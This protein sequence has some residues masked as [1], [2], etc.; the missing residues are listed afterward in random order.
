MNARKLVLGILLIAFALPMPSAAI[1]GQS[2]WKPQTSEKSMGLEISKPFLDG[3]HLSVLSTTSFLWVQWPIHEKIQFVG[4]LPLAYGSYDD[5]FG[6]ESDFVL[7]N[8]YLGLRFGEDGSKLSGQF[9]VRLPVT[10][11]HSNPALGVGLF[12]DFISRPGAFWPDNVPVTG[13][14]AYQVRNEQGLVLQVTGGADAWIATESGYGDR[15]EAWGL[16][17]ARAGYDNQVWAFSGGLAGRAILTES[18][19]SFA[20]RTVHELGLDIGY[21][22]TQVQPNLFVRFPLDKGL[23]ENLNLVVGFGIRTRM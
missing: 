5:E 11:S 20:D 13:T 15:V 3:G 10:P 1:L 12:S 8:P 23:R 17:G 7:G 9:G 2:L 4:E 14:V 22:D 21:L 18:G 19:G 16:Y 6:G